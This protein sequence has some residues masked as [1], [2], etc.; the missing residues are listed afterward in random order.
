MERSF[1]SFAPAAGAGI[2]ADDAPWPLET[3]ASHSQQV[4]GAAAATTAGPIDPVSA[5]EAGEDWMNSIMGDVGNGRAGAEADPPPAEVPTGAGDVTV[6]ATIAADDSAVARE[7]RPD[8]AEPVAA[9]GT[10]AVGSLPT[11]DESVDA[12]MWLEAGQQRGAA[13]DSHAGTALDPPLDP[14][15]APTPVEEG[16][17][18]PSAGTAP[19]Q[20]ASA[21]AEPPAPAASDTPPGIEISLPP[22]REASEPV[23]AAPA[24]VKPTPMEKVPPAAEGDQGEGMLSPGA[25]LLCEEALEEEETAA[26]T[27]TMGGSGQEAPNS[28]DLI[29]LERGTLEAGKREREGEGGNK[30]EQRPSRRQHPAAAARQAGKPAATAL[31]VDVDSPP[32]AAG[33]PNTPGS[34]RSRPQRTCTQRTVVDDDDDDDDDSIFDATIPVKGPGG[35]AAGAA[36]A[37]NVPRRHAPEED[38]EDEAVAILLTLHNPKHFDE[39]KEEA[40]FEWE[41]RYQVSDSRHFTAISTLFSRRFT[42]FHRRFTHC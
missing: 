20:E 34:A 36:S 38:E 5:D 22:P 40:A 1:N 30:L 23:Q 28:V 3:G 12:N 42:Q 18:E 41:R 2:L 15:S 32:A 21:A 17:R 11:E 19:A 33:D 24:E 26:G 10:A 27:S 13:R 37:S 14:P 16:A 31:A 7:P 35:S 8:A 9:E 29:Q 39:V 4:S 6:G 25:N